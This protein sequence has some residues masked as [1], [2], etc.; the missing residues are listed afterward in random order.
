MPRP[1]ADVFVAGLGALSDSAGRGRARFDALLAEGRRV[2][3]EG[4]RAVQEALQTVGTAA[5]RAGEIVVEALD[6]QLHRAVEG[7]LAG[8]DLP[9]RAEFDALRV[10]VHR[11]SACVAEISGEP[12][13]PVD[14]A[15]GRHADGWEVR[16]EGRETPEAVHGTKKAALAAGRRLARAHAPSRLVVYRTD[17][18]LGESVVYSG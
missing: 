14:V 9:T 16:V 1:S 8:A 12:V 15:I 17:G 3:A 13:P 18:S 7:V 6:D 11:L 5:A 2:Q 10:G 4:G